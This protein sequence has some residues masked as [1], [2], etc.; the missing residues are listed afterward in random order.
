[1]WQDEPYSTLIQ[2]EELIDEDFCFR[3][4]ETISDI[5]MIFP[6]AVQI[7]INNNNNSMI[8]S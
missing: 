6:Q 7:E 2:Q 3:D 8:T 5:C 1:M 4:E